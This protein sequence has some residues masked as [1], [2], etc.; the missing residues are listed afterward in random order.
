MEKTAAIY[1]RVSS[2]LQDIENSIHAQV[3][4]CQDYAKKE[5]YSLHD[6]YI[7]RAESGRTSDR[8]EFQRMIKEARGKNFDIILVHKLD[9]FARNRED[10]VTYKALLRKHGIE[11]FSVTEQLGDDIY[12]RLIEGILEVVA[13]F[14]SLNLATE[15]RKGQ[16]QAIED[17]YL[18][19][20]YTPYGY[21]AVRD[22]ERK[23]LEIDPETGPIIKKLFEMSASGSAMKDL[24]L[25][26][27][28]SKLKPKR[29]ARWGRRLVRLLLEG[30]AVTG[31][32]KY[33]GMRIEN[34]HPAII[35]KETFEKSKEQ[36][37]RWRG[38][39]NPNH[40]VY[41]LVG[42]A[43][44]DRCGGRITSKSTDRGKYKYYLC[45]YA[46]DK[47][48]LAQGTCT[49]KHALADDVEQKVK[50]LVI[51]KLE[52]YN[53]NKALLEKGKTNQD[54]NKKSDEEELLK[55]ELKDIEKQKENIINAIV[56]GINPDH[57]KQ[58]LD[59]LS[60]RKNQIEEELET[61]KKPSEEICHPQSLA[62]LIQEA[63]PL[64][65]KNLYKEQIS[66]KLDLVEKTGRLRIKY[67]YPEDCWFDFNY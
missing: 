34:A 62:K 7:D 49:T 54:N 64:Q 50:E 5:G 38:I 26:L 53:L 37:T 44:C 19:H 28:S 43:T 17:G 11:L 12:G 51:E 4:N 59:E 22:G 67:F 52:N 36:R 23:R 30:E 39:R 31:V 3:K 1:A 29:A 35:S 46:I 63:S 65:L 47:G 24:M 60:E 61:K 41:H 32:R 48:V 42:A 20:G 9:R 13:E 21:R 33:K 55:T 2:A 40:R 16:K 66:V 56:T 58:K 8:P 57:F 45:D 14:Y 25:F 6:I 27:N 15:I 10:A 18:G